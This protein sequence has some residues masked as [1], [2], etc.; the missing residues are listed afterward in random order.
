MTIGSSFYFVFIF[1]FIYF[2]HS[3]ICI[4][5]EF[6]WFLTAPIFCVSAFLLFKSKI[7]CKNFIL[8]NNNKNEHK[9]I[10]LSFVRFDINISI[11]NRKVVYVIII[12]IIIISLFLK[13][14]NPIIFT[15]FSISLCILLTNTSL[16]L[17]LFFL[18]IWHKFWAAKR[19]KFGFTYSTHFVVEKRWFW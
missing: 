7:R 10:S 12:I 8:N 13:L 3:Q 4:E 14:L 15:L 18:F 1:V 6:K 5:K 17:I 16:I 11:V 2:V 9:M 19:L